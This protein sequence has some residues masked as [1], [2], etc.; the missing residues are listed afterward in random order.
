M[1]IA[2]LCLYLD[3]TAFT[4]NWISYLFVRFLPNLFAAEAIIVFTFQWVTVKTII[5]YQK[6]SSEVREKRV[7]RIKIAQVLFIMIVPI[8]MLTIIIQV[9]TGVNDDN[10]E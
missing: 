7:L 5:D 10:N 8:A 2:R 1:F 3:K 4:F 9:I 6:Y